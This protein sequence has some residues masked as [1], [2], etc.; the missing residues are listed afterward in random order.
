MCA[1]HVNITSLTAN[2][3]TCIAYLETLKLKFDIICF[4]GTWLREDYQIE[5]Y[6]PD[7][8]SFHSMRTGRSGGGVSIFISNKYKSSQLVDINS[9]HLECIF[10]N[11]SYGD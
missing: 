8:T 11:L 10:A 1:I 2:G 4:S 5:N 9:D 3:N 7:Y 6:F